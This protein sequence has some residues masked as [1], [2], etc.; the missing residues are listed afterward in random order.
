[1]AM[2]AA[3]AV[4]AAST[5]RTTSAVARKVTA[6]DRTRGPQTLLCARVW[7]A[8][9]GRAPSKPGLGLGTAAR[10]ARPQNQE[11][12]HVHEHERGHDRPRIV[13]NQ[14]QKAE[15]E[16]GDDTG[17]QRRAQRQQAGG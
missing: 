7:P 4:T 16:G 14:G 13:E 11:R 1:M 6:A 2:S 9:P 10:L 12:S 5:S 15:H 17:S 3:T 8:S